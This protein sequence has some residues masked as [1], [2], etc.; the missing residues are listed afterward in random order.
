[1]CDFMY[2]KSQE[3]CILNK[4]CKT[5]SSSRDISEHHPRLSAFTYSILIS[6]QVFC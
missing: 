6:E 3:I 4:I 5:S 2:K 1:M